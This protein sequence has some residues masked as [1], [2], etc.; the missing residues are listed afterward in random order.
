MG[1]HVI[2]HHVWGHVQAWHNDINVLNRFSLVTNLLK[3]E[4]AS[5]TFIMKYAYVYLKNY[6]LTNVIYVT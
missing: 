1:V 4:F 5:M 3:G 2:G 6:L